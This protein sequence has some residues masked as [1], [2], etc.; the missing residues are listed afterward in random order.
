MKQQRPIR[1]AGVGDL[2][3]AVARQHED[4]V[5]LPFEGARGGAL[6][7]PYGRETASLDDVDRFVE[8]EPQPR[9]RRAG[10]NLCDAGLCDALLARELEERGTTFPL[11]PVAQVD[12]AQIVDEIPLMHGQVERI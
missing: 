12:S 10:G 8:C 1:A 4:A 6:P 7:L 5:L 11:S 3:G 2:M 9:Q